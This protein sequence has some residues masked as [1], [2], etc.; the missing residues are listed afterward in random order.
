MT[1]TDEVGN[2]KS[3]SKTH[4]SMSR[5]WKFEDRAVGES[6]ECGEA[7]VSQAPDEP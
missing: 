7:N 2:M 1:N 3:A 5:S 4:N 6:S